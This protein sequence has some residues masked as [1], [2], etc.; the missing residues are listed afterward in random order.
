MSLSVEECEATTRTL[1]ESHEEL[2]Q[3]ATLKETEAGIAWAKLADVQKQLL[4]MQARLLQQ[5]EMIQA[6]L[7]NLAAGRG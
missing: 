3:L 5:Q 1:K 2:R 7:T 6:L 4:D